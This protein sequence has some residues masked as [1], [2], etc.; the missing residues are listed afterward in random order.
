MKVK[1]LPQVFVFALIYTVLFFQ[2]KFGLN[3]LFLDVLVISWFIVS[4]QLKLK[5]INQSFSLAGMLLTAIFSVLYYSKLAHISHVIF[6][7]YFIGAQSL[8]NAKS[9][10][11]AIA[12]SITNMFYAPLALIQKLF[13]FKIKGKRFGRWLWNLKFYFLPII[14]IIFFIAIYRISNPVFNNLVRNIN[15]WLGDNIFWFFS[16]IDGRVIS[17]FLGA[18]LIGAFVFYKKVI[19]GVQNQNDSSTDQLLRQKKKHIFRFNGLKTEN[20][21][22]I[23]LFVVLNFILLII[24]IIDIDWVWFNFQWEGQYLK[25]FVHSGTYLLILSIIVSIFVV[26]YFFRNNQNFYS[27]NKFLKI[28][29]YIWM[30]QNAILAISVAIR[31]IYYISIFNLAFKRIAV[32]MFLAFILFGLFSVIVKILRRKSVFYLVKVNVFSLLTILLLSNFVNWDIFIAKYNFNHSNTAFI[33]LDYLSDLSDK[34]LPYLDKSMKELE[35][36][37]QTQDSNFRFDYYYMSPEIYFKH[38]QTRKELFKQ[39][40]ERKTFLEWNYAEYQAYHN[41]RENQ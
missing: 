14:L 28:L 18:M 24:N 8:I 17:T 20:K 22:G 2:K 32:F 37:S 29:S 40:W 39:K 41:L 6:V 34:T 5:N 23:F 35:K 36:I 12:N 33:H 1:F 10:G 19:Q 26:L 13:S 31:N 4:K 25:Q 7:V 9:P 27:K 16:S 30:G 15:H 3:L 21:V 11:M 38:I